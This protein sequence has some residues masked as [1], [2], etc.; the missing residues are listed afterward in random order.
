MPG[1]T[2]DHP[3]ILHF[4]AKHRIAVLSVAM[5]DGSVHSA[6]V[7]YSHQ[8]EPFRLFFSTPNDTRKY[9]A[10]AAGNGQAIKAAVTIGFN[11][12][13]WITFQLDG[14][15]RVAVAGEENNHATEVHFTKYPD[16]K[17]YATDPT[18]VRLIFTPF[19]YRYTEFRR[20][21]RLI[22]EGK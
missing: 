16:Y 15:L 1:I 22:I 18:R 5:P 10:V 8:N 12:E 3:E 17:K 14:E 19:W 4:V 20:E 21:P 7:H 11:E 2:I 6:T 9:Q 13:E